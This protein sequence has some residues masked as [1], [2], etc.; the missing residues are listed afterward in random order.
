MGR[1]K[2]SE[3]K[4]CLVQLE[5]DDLEWAVEEAR[6]NERSVAAQVRYALRRYR[7]SQEK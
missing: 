2:L 5:G 1:P 7:E 3:V 6:K 4:K